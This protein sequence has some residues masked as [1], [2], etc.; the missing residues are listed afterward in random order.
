MPSRRILLLTDDLMASSRIATAAG[1]GWSVDVRRGAVPPADATACDVVLIDLQSC[2]DPAPTIAALRATAGFSA[3][4]VV[5]GPHVWQERLDAALAAGADAT[6]TR[7]EVM[8]GLGRVL[9]GLD[10][11]GS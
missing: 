9:A 7:G 5:F 1:G 4:I 3:S 10:R 8:Q 6:A 11:P 2:P